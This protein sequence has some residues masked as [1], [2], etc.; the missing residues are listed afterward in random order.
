MPQDA[1]TLKYLCSELK[2]VFVSGKVNRIICPNND[3]AIFTVYTGKNTEKLFLSV[4]PSSP[5]IG[6]IENDKE[7]PL[8]ASNF[9]MLLR[10][11]LLSSEITDLSLIGF[12]RIV[13]IDFLSSSEFSDSVV[14]TLFI[15]LM[16]RYS[17]IILTENGKVL[18]AN[19][20]INMFDNGVRPL[21]VGKSYVFPPTNDKKLPTD[22]SLIEYF[23]VCDSENI[24][25]YI[26]KG[27]QGIAFDT[28]NEIAK[29]FNKPLTGNGKEFFDFL[30][31]FLFN[32]V[33][34]P[35]VLYEDEKV[36]DVFVYPYSVKGK[37]KFFNALYQAENFYFSV[38]EE[39]K[40]FE[41]KAERL[42]S[43][44]SS[45]MKKVKKRL[46]LINGKYTDAKDAEVN[47]LKGEILL[48]NIYKIEKGVKEVELENYYD[49]S[50]IVISLNENISVAD[51]AEAYYKKYAKKKRTVIAIVPQKEQ[52]ESELKYL[53]SV[54]EEICL[55]KDIEDLLLVQNEMEE[56]GLIDKPKNLKKKIE[57]SKYRTY[58]YSG[59]I[60]RCGRNNFE[61]DKL[62]FSSKP[63]DIWLHVKDYH[64]SH[65]VISTE[66]K[67]VPEKVVLFASE[68]CA[69][70]SKCRDTGNVEV[71]YTLKKHVKKPPKS[72]IGFCTYTDF[73]SV[74]VKP[75]FHEEFLKKE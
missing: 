9:C 52:A 27:V 25:D 20:G 73:K 65:V 53:E 19:R 28:A 58:N 37:F 17:N 62:T 67:E 34:N 43:I 21:I 47:R 72:A 35:C 29:K 5:R 74:V 8:T 14:K 49:G 63:E 4:N 69:Y 68:L 39:N 7:S 42:K 51:N 30:N 11:H 15:E 1:Y 41:L 26:C 54:L 50:K 18:G 2:S 3:E 45:K 10:K 56:A 75:D 40:Q 22:I 44:I 71:V 12:D 24:P 23:D 46:S 32:T 57:S 31:K 64:S 13:K 48:A 61:N 60:I 16:G 38:K 59:F 33:P 36:K 55:S 70:F 6:I 66:N